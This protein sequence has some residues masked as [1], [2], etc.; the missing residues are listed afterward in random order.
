MSKIVLVTGASRGIGLEAAKHFSREGYR[1]IGTSRGDFNLGELIG[2]ERAISAQLDLM[3][4]ESIKNLFAELKSEDLLPSVLVNNAGITKDQ[5]FLRMKDEDW[6]K[7]INVNLTAA[8]RLTKQ[9]IKGMIKNRYGRVIF[10]SS[11]VGYTGNAGQTNY[12]ASKSALVGLNKSLALEVASRGITCNL[13]APGFI[14]TPMTDKLSDEQKNNIVKNI[15]VNRL[16]LPDDISNACVYLA[17]EEA[18]YITGSTLHIN[19]GM[20]M[21]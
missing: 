19:G 11:V 4:K 16:G 6:D 9:V 18:S 1:V 15:P 3:S 12:S 2:D 8:M 5:L 20:S 14:S 21:I 13:I 10:I 7:V 17:S